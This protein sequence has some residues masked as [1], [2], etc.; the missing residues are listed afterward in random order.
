MNAPYETPYQTPSS[1]SA[2]STVSGGKKRLKS[3]NPLRAGLVLGVLYAIMIFIAV[4][5]IIPFGLTG[6]FSGSNS[7]GG[8]EAA[9]MGIGMGL[10]MLILGPLIYGVVGFIGGVISA[11]I[12]NL[13]AK[14][15]GGLEFTLEDVQ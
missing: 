14:L 10:G 4:L 11:W 3:V 9:G 8:T 5:V 13:V 12:Y 1:N 7:I 15:T 2:S 6:L